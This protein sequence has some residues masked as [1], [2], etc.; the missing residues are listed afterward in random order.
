MDARTFFDKVALMRE[1]Q[2]KYFKTKSSIYHRKSKELEKEID[3]EI[4]RVKSIL[5]ISPK[6]Y[7]EQSLFDK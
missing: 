6:T 2:I 3:T 5:G 1:Y 7:R 4:D